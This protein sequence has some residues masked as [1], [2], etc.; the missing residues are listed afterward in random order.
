M[1]TSAECAAKVYWHPFRRH[2][3]VDRGGAA[4][5]GRR[6]SMGRMA[7]G[8]YYD[9]PEAVC[10]YDALRFGLYEFGILVRGP[11]RQ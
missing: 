2:A 10:Y 11:S 9:M 3:G 4:C 1:G 8:Q 6:R 7:S 5:S